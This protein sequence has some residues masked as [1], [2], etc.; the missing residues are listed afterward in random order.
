MTPQN[1][2]RS[3]YFALLRDND[4]KL[5]HGPHG[6]R[7]RSVV[8]PCSRETCKGYT[9]SRS[10]RNLQEI[11]YLGFY[12]I[13]TRNKIFLVYDRCTGNTISRRLRDEYK[14]YVT[15]LPTTELQ[16]NAVSRH[17]REIYKK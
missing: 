12:E 7:T 17:L 14:K 6:V 2:R 5:C 13:C 1:N 8:I 4:I 9:I 3:K 10:T 15:L 11:R 16:K